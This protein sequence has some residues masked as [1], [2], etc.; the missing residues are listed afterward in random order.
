MEYHSALK[1]KGILTHK[2]MWMNLEGVVLSKVSQAQKKKSCMSPLMG[3]SRIVSSYSR[4]V[5]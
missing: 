3:V 4:K 5:Q 1:R 2:T